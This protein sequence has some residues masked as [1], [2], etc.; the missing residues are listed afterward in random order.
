M[1]S[2]IGPRAPQIHRRSIVEAMA[3]LC[4][5]L[6]A[7]AVFPALASADGWCRVDPIIR[8]D[9]KQASIYVV[10]EAD[11]AVRANSQANVTIEYPIGADGELVWVD[12]NHGFGYGLT[13][14]M[15]PSPGVSYTEEGAEIRI[16]VRMTTPHVFEPMM[17]EWAPGQAGSPTTASAIGETNRFVVLE[18][19]LAL[20]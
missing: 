11:S 4:A 16:T 13:V 20:S 2:P 1:R 9:G 19:V 14:Q 6:I 18:T 12:P 3:V 5:A 10:T 15:V 7:A 8:V 17:I